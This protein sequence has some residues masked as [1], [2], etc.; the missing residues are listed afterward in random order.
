MTSGMFVSVEAARCC[1][2]L[3]IPTARKF[4]IF[5]IKIMKE[6]IKERIYIKI[7][8]LLIQSYL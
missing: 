2:I 4:C 1:G 7:N 3:R 6:N 8:H 5:K